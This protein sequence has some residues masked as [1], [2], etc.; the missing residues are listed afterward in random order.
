MKLFFYFLSINSCNYAINYCNSPRETPSQKMTATTRHLQQA[1]PKGLGLTY[2][3]HPITSTLPQTASPHTK[4]NNKKQKKPYPKQERPQASHYMD[5]QQT[6]C[7]QTADT[8]PP[9]LTTKETPGDTKTAVWPQSTS[10]HP[11]TV[12]SKIRIKEI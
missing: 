1:C 11:S 6:I 2:Q 9:Q 8:Q 3:R 5:P 10:I 12:I 4:K 7:T